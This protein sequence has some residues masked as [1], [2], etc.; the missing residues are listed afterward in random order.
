MF[1]AGKSRFLCNVSKCARWILRFQ[2]LRLVPG[3]FAASNRC[4]VIEFLM[5]E[6]AW[7]ISY[8]VVQWE[9]KIKKECGS[10]EILFPLRR[11]NRWQRGD[12]RE[13]RMFGCPKQHQPA[14][15]AERRLCCSELLFPGG[16]VDS[17]AGLDEYL[18]AQSKKLRKGRVDRRHLRGSPGAYLC[19]HY[20]NFARIDYRRS[21]TDFDFVNATWNKKTGHFQKNVLFSLDRPEVLVYNKRVAFADV[22]QWQSVRFPSRIRGFDSRHLLQRE[23]APPNG[24]AFSFL[25]RYWIRTLSAIWRKRM[26]GRTAC[27]FAL[28]LPHISVLI[29]VICFFVQKPW[30]IKK[31]CYN[32]STRKHRRR[33]LPPID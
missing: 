27:R 16:W 9:Y 4:P 26:C 1:Y 19:G 21:C 23:R 8:F 20:R 14:G 29:P 2:K 24:C 31:M 15:R 32:K 6:K 25:T 17:L 11:T 18:S 33:L 10:N 13:M 5:I 3:T 12:L 22:T 28:L 7:Q 30:Q